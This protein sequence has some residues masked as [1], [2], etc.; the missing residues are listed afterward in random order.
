MGNRSTF[1][2]DW[3]YDKRPAEIQPTAVS[4][5]VYAL[6][7]GEQ[8]W[9]MRRGGPV[10]AAVTLIALLA[11]FPSLVGAAIPKH[12]RHL[13]RPQTYRQHAVAT[14]TGGAVASMELHASRAGIRV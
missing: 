7:A 8:R 4:R 14:G 10:L 12:R 9:Q 6:D 5:T 2:S 13:P 3:S 11:V 1:R